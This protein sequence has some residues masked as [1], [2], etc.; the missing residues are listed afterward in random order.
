VSERS[1]GLGDI[2]APG[3]PLF[4]VIEPS[5]LRL[6][7]AVPAASATSLQIG[8]PVKFEVQGFEGKPFEG[9]IE[10]ISPMRLVS[11]HGVAAIPVS[12]FLQ[13]G[14]PSGPVLRFCFAKKDETL[15]RAAERLQRV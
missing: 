3:T 6:E 9:K 8:T 11:E 2:V 12:P 15:Q 10:R 14:E 5:S 4:T 7:G 13:P 1:I